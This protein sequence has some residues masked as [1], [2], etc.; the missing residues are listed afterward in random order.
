MPKAIVSTFLHQGLQF[1]K[2]KRL[3]DHL[4][5]TINKIEI[6]FHFDKRGS[7]IT[8]VYIVMNIIYWLPFFTERYE[9]IVNHNS[10]ATRSRHYCGRYCIKHQ[11]ENCFL[12][13]FL[14]FINLLFVFSLSQDSV[15]HNTR[16]LIKIFRVM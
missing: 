3:D 5:S 10:S 15:T 2:S 6:L 1:P 7:Q 12:P 14:L 4:Q 16:I 8:L 9:Q 13:L 11:S